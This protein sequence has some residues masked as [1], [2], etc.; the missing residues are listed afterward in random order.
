MPKTKRG[1]EVKAN[2]G[3]LKVK[4]NVG[5]LSKGR[6]YKCN[7]IK[8]AQWLRLGIPEAGRQKQ[9][10]YELGPET[11]SEKMERSARCGKMGSVWERKVGCKSEMEQTRDL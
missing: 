2:V 6:L 1:K 5:H 8:R 9:C 3:H 7:T 4:A 10:D 11:H